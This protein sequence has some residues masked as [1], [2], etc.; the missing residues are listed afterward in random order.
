MT[1]PLP[2][3]GSAFAVRGV[4]FSYGRLQVLFDVSLEV[5]R[6]EALALLGTNGA[7]KSTLLRVAAGLERPSVGAVELDG[8]NITGSTAE[9]RVRDGL[10]L[11]PGGRSVFGDLTVAENLQM[12]GFVLRR[13]PKQL[14]AR[15]DDAFAMF[16]RLA[17]RRD[18]RAGTLSGGEQQQLALCKAVIL[19]PKVLCIDEL[20]LGLAPTV[21]ATLLESLETIR[22]SGVSLIVVEQS[23]NVAAWVCER[24]VFMEKGAIRF[25]GRTAELLERDDLARAVFLGSTPPAGKTKARTTTTRKTTA[26]KRP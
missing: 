14:R 12:T 6:G 10:I 25:E 21:V 11:I 22:S 19:R 2:S 17:E 18:Q 23:L 26:R 24:A 15:V 13:N 5:G 8:R 20:S 4:D 7:G 3:T 9:Q 16:P 1:A